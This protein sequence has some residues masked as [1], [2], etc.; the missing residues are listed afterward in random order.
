LGIA[1]S[2]LLTGFIILIFWLFNGKKIDRK[3]YGFFLI[4]AVIILSISPIL[5]EI[6]TPLINHDINSANFVLSTLLSWF[7]GPRF[8]AFPMVS[9]TIIGTIFGII[10]AKKER[11]YFIKRV[12][13]SVGISCIAISLFGG[14]IKYMGFHFQIDMAWNPHFL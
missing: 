7:I 1:L 10:L 13:I 3:I 2:V 8:P 9:Y 14:F 4:V 11:W 6:L 12:G 5:A